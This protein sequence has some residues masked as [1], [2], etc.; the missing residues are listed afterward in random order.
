MLIAGLVALYLVGAL[1]GFVFA[2]SKK[3]DWWGPGHG[4]FH[5]RSYGGKEYFTCGETCNEIPFLVT[6][7]WFAIFG[8]LFCKKITTFFYNKFMA[9]IDKTLALQDVIACWL[10]L[11]KEKKAKKTS[12]KPKPSNPSPSVKEGYRIAG[13]KPCV[14]CGSH[15]S[16]D[17]SKM[18]VAEEDDPLDPYG[19]YDRAGAAR[20]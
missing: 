16:V 8:Y 1:A 14:A 20:L 18:E 9:G 6:F 15:T 17:Q 2:A 7:F 13:P 10:K 3:G 11:R 5:N 4:H 12:I 19:E